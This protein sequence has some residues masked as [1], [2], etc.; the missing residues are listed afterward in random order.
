MLICS[1]GRAIFNSFGEVDDGN[2]KG[3][4]GG[5]RGRLLRRDRVSWVARDIRSRSV[6]EYKAELLH[7]YSLPRSSLIIFRRLISFFP[8]NFPNYTS[9]A[10]ITRLDLS[11]EAGAGK[12]MGIFTGSYHPMQPPN[13]IKTQM[14][15]KA[16][17]GAISAR[18]KQ[19]SKTSWW[20]QF[21]FG[22]QPGMLLPV[23]EIEKE[24]EAKKAHRQ[25]AIQSDKRR[26]L[27]EVEVMEERSLVPK[28]MEPKQKAVEKRQ[29]QR[30]TV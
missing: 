8:G 25:L 15:R 29:W 26:G 14:K 12:K 17:E 18:H 10:L 23:R 11:L 21:R 30:R 2:W 3:N 20:C 4:L 13:C 16:V 27:K 1:G 22:D 28:E 5:G 19:K 7:D 9:V 6:I 24:E